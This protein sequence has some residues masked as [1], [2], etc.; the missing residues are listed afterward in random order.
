[1]PASEAAARSPRPSTWPAR[2]AASL[3]CAQCRLQH[4]VAVMRKIRMQPDPAAIAAR[5]SPAILSRAR[6]PARLD[7]QVALAAKLGQAWRMS[8]AT[9]ASCRCAAPTTRR[10]PAPTRPGWPGRGANGEAGWQ[11]RIG[12]GQRQM[13]KCFGRHG[14]LAPE[15]GQASGAVWNGGEG[16]GVHGLYSSSGKPDCA[17]IAHHGPRWHDDDPDIRGFCTTSAHRAVRRFGKS[18]QVPGYPA[19]TVKSPHSTEHQDATG[20]IQ[21]RTVRPS[22]RAAPVAA[23]T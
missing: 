5:Y 4:A 17:T 9:P 16:S 23:P 22:N 10:R 1:M 18:P 15:R 14:G 2:R 3:S 7:A 8:T 21:A 12:A 6:A 13:P 19:G 11:H 20:S